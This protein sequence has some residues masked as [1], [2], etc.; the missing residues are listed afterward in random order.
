MKVVLIIFFCFFTLQVLAQSDFV[1]TD[2]EIASAILN[3]DKTK[4][5]FATSKNL[6]ILN[7]NDFKIEQTLNLDAPKNY[8]VK[9]IKFIKSNKDVL[10]V[11]FV[12]TNAY[13]FAEFRHDIS[14]YPRDSIFGYSINK[15][16]ITTKF[17][18][19][20]YA[21]YTRNFNEYIVAY[22]DYYAYLS[23]QGDS[24]FVSRKGELM[25][26]P[27][28][29]RVFNNGI[30]RGLKF[31][32]N[33]T[34]FTIVYYDSLSNKDSK[35]HY[36]IEKR[37]FPSLEVLNTVS[38]I[39]KPEEI[40]YS[41]NNAYFLIK[42]KKGLYEASPEYSYEYYDN[43]TFKRIA[44]FPENIAIDGLIEDGSVW[45][46]FD[47]TII[48][49]R[50]KDKTIQNKI[51]SNLTPFT[52]IDGFFKI[53]DN[54]ILYGNG[55]SD[56]STKT[57]FFK[58]PIEEGTYYSK[59]ED[60]KFETDSLLNYEKP[61]I[62]NNVLRIGFNQLIFKN[63]FMMN[64]QSSV[65]EIW[66][67][68]QKRK[69]F[70]VA[71][72]N[73]ISAFLSE[74]ETYVLIIEASNQGSSFSNF[75][76]KVLDLNTG[77]ITSKA[78]IDNKELKSFNAQNA[79]CFQDLN[80]KDTWTCF[81]YASEV[82]KINAT[83][84]EVSTS[85]DLDI[86]SKYSYFINDVQKQ[87]Q[88]DTYLLSVTT[89][90]AYDG[91]EITSTQVYNS[92]TRSTAP[93]FL[94]DYYSFK[95][96][97]DSQVV[98]ENNSLIT[99]YDWK[100]KKEYT[101]PIEKG[102]NMENAY[103]EKERIY[104]VAFQDRNF[105]TK[106]LYSIDKDNYTREKEQD[107]PYSNVFSDD[108][109]NLFLDNGNQILEFDPVTS[110][111][112]N[113]NNT[114][115]D[116]SIS[117]DDFQ[118]NDS[119]TILFKSKY[120]FDLKTLE[121]KN[122]KSGFNNRLLLK[123]E[124]NDYMLSLITD[125]YSEG[126][127]NFK[128]AI[129]SLSDANEK[130]WESP[131]N[132]ESQEQ[133]P[134]Y[135]KLSESGKL[136]ILYSNLSSVKF[137][138]LFHLDT[139]K[140]T[141]FKL[142]NI[143][144]LGINRLTISQDDTHILV[145]SWNQKGNQII[146]KYNLIT[147]ALEENEFLDLTED[148]STDALEALLTIKDFGPS[149]VLKVDDNIKL[150]LK[151]NNYRED[152]FYTKKYITNAKYFS[153]EELLVG[154]S[155]SGDLEIWDI[156]QKYP[157]KSLKLGS[158]NVLEVK[159]AKNKLYVLL[160]NSEIKV[161]D[162]KTLSLITTININNK[163]DE[164]ALAY[165]MH[166]GYFKASKEDIRNF[167]FV[168][169][170]NSFPLLNYE[171]FL[172]RPDIILERFGYA[173]S[174]VI[175]IYRQAYLKR[176]KRN[177]FNEKTDYLS[178]KKPEVKLLNFDDINKSSA[179]DQLE[180]SLGT[181]INTKTFAI[182]INGVPVDK[183][184]TNS[185]LKHTVNVV[186]NAGSNNITILGT[187]ENGI[188]SDP[189]TF[190]VENTMSVKPGKLYYLG[191]GVSK[192]ADSSMNLRFADKDVR[193]L[194][195]LFSNKF[196]NKV[197]IDTLTNSD[198][199]QQNIQNLKTKLI[200]TSINDIV[201]ISFSGHGLVDNDDNFYFATHNIDFKKPEENGF[202][203]NAIQALLDDIPARRK[204]L[205]IDACHSGEIDAEANTKTKI[206]SN[207]NIKT[208]QPKGTETESTDGSKIGLQTS[209]ELM[210]SLFYDLDRGNGSFIISA[211]GGLEYAFES[212]EW[213]NGVFTYSI[214]NAFYDLGSDLT[215]SE[216]K[217]YVYDNVKTLTEDNQKPTSRQ[218]NIEWDWAFD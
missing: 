88:S 12:K 77:L 128:L 65:M 72:H 197:E 178:L 16:E 70:D 9:S 76:L 8:K 194:A 146:Q 215:I 27:E 4:I 60:N 64:I 114:L 165:L 125:R 177:G 78:Y 143:G 14:E 54:L 3:F 55:S 83:N 20:L 184:L 191:I 81:N 119:G 167:H 10:L 79:K 99:F 50:I 152:V 101:I 185:K 68:K 25:A 90:D 59:I 200:N 105:K 214:I 102:W 134:E 31:A 201:V 15:G 205:L 164:I 153:D 113:W 136:A 28:K 117:S 157:K 116:I 13:G 30:I 131:K 87:Q 33:N 112:V 138:Y 208:Y 85:H 145:G 161:I 209:F 80:K 66:N 48:Q 2:E 17:S 195:K 211:A 159:K 37:A 121:T 107:I 199:T 5:A 43:K 7:V 171:L 62:Q 56:F 63:R 133:C 168:K 57:G 46:L 41:N 190:N 58:Y 150:Q 42:K 137:I 182:Y 186:L 39:G 89:K 38:T 189:V 26:F 192:Y 213:N 74:D 18:G 218:E 52:S 120:L 40:I 129:S 71:F 108:I 176:L 44:N 51:W 207:K 92:N 173:D 187:D 141:K 160:Q 124:L 94:P 93:I 118:I 123:G 61:S 22:N 175:E 181:D 29:K 158:Y 23:S 147:N 111:T 216:L 179:S 6:Y 135:L 91:E 144:D 103:L 49:L 11:K 53:K 155:S 203:Y 47:N 188:E 24:V 19:N 97:R 204:L 193:S 183:Q 172:N 67:I 180:L 210:K 217:K 32:P 202:S 166:D 162:L 127:P 34:E 106:K 36:S 132:Y 151:K 96:L 45:N 126:K 122:L 174:E 148:N 170:L 86:E 84:L 35:N 110:N 156:T 154:Y 142:K 163:K 115:S 69:L 139:K 196:E 82:F 1:E 95:S 73:D 109:G 75:N 130:K 206:L 98:Y 169:G 198:V 140:I 104:V 100:T 21:D 149:Y 212:K